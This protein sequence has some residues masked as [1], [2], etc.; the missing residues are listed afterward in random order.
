MPG[1]SQAVCAS[2][3][4]LDEQREAIVRSAACIAKRMAAMPRLT[5]LPALTA[6]LAGC[7]S[8]PPPVIAFRPT[9]AYVDF[10]GASRN[11]PGDLWEIYLKSGGAEIHMPRSIPSRTSS[12]GALVL[13]VEVEPP[14]AEFIVKVWGETR[15]PRDTHFTVPV[16]VGMI[17]PVRLD[18]KVVGSIPSQHTSVDIYATFYILRT[19]DTT[20]SI[21]KYEV[22][23]ETPIQWI[24]LGRVPYNYFGR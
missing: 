2:L 15:N 11:S 13:R 16:R 21:F 10:Y 24:E 6:I 12:A 9:A 7:A 22:T 23:P 19:R 8:S 18:K 4:L 3:K 1:Q 20:N 17:T 5:L 14:A